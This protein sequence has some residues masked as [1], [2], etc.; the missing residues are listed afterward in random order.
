MEISTPFQDAM[1]L[2]VPHHLHPHHH[3]LP[4]RQRTLQWN[5]SFSELFLSIAQTALPQV[6]AAAAGVATVT[7]EKTS[8][9]HLPP[10][11]ESK[12][13]MSGNIA[14][15]LSP[16]RYLHL[17]IRISSQWMNP[18]LEGSQDLDRFKMSDIR[19]AAIKTGLWP[20]GSK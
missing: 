20:V 19:H 4:R 8:L 10:T 14:T 9:P 16:I 5:L 2:P 11:L 15:V 13:S 18:F 3:P 6:V 7:A 1:S 17:R 12:R